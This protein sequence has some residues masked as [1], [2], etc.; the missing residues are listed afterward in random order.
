MLINNL[1]IIGIGLIGGSLARALRARGQVKYITAYDTCEKSLKKALDLNIIDNYSLDVKES[2]CDA[3]VLVIATPISTTEKILPQITEAL[4]KNTIVTDVGSVKGSIVKVAREV[5]GENF[6]NFVPGHPIAG[7]EQS[8]F[9]ASFAELFVDHIVILTP[10]SETSSSANKLISRMWELIGAKIIYIDVS[11]HDKT[12]A[13]TSHLPH[14]LAY[15]LV[16]C[17]SKMEAREDVFKYAAGG[18]SDFTRIASSNPEMWHD[19]CIANSKALINVLDMFSCHVEKI[20]K[21]IYEKDS[22]SLLDIFQNAKQT[23]DKFIMTKNKLNTT[24]E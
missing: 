13:A 7:T 23:R 18:F 15:L 21:A 8:G 11:Y 16:D 17:L 22:K 2:V 9:E 20:R 6:P 3:D 14:M 12:L 5:M 10:L 19:I 4:S 24:K 1:S